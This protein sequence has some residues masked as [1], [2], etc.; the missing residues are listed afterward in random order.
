MFRIKFLGLDIYGCRE[1]T[2]RL[3]DYVDGELALDETKKVAQHLKIC[4]ECEGK[5]K[6]ERDLVAGLRE[7][8]GQAETNEMPDVS[9]LKER[10]GAVLETEKAGGEN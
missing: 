8:V 1:A 6:F 2:E 4:R 7:K 5:F 3:D 9:A 10:I